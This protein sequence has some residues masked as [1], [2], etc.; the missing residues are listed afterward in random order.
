MYRTTQLHYYTHGM[1]QYFKTLD[2]TNFSRQ[3]KIEEI[4]KRK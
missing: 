1:T 2:S 3:S 4:H